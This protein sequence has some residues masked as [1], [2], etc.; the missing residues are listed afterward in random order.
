M[1]G[2]AGDALQITDL[3]S[4]I[5]LGRLLGNVPGPDGAP[6]ETIQLVGGKTAA[7]V[8]VVPNERGKDVMVDPLCLGVWR[9]VVWRSSQGATTAPGGHAPAEPARSCTRQGVA[10]C[11]RPPTHTPTQ[12]RLCACSW[13]EE[14]LGRTL[15]SLGEQCLRRLLSCPL[16]GGLDRV[17]DE[18]WPRGGYPSLV[19]GSMHDQLVLCTGSEVYLLAPGWP[20][21]QHGDA[22]LAGGGGG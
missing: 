16:R 18:A 3:A 1:D 4:A 7:R 20:A 21:T 6:C 9:R 13:R 17:E 19:E 2:Q 22:V 5:A 10:H 14:G 15:V 8:I 11:R 12:G